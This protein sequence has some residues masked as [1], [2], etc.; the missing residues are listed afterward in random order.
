MIYS[1]KTV[2]TM[3]SAKMEV[4]RSNFIGWAAPAENE[5]EAIRFIQEINSIH[6]EATHNCF[7]FSVGITNVIQRINDDGEP[8]GTAGRPILEVI[9]NLQLKNV[10]VVVTRYFG[11]TLLGTGGLVRA[12]TRAAQI[13]IDAAEIIEKLLYSNIKV[14]V[15]YTFFG[16]LQNEIIKLNQLIKKIDYTDNVTLDLMVEYE[17]KSS[18]VDKL[19]EITGGQMILQEGPDYFLPNP[20]PNK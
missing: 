2:K 3:G 12:Y 5:D 20:N 6:R 4:K 9:Q 18:V 10:V 11:G 13:G 19:R 14:T 15:D 16:K 7:A 8:S 17:L 1:Y